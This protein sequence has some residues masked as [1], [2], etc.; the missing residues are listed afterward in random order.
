MYVAVV[1][2]MGVHGPAMF[3]ADSQR[4]T[5]PLKPATV[6]VPLFVVPQTLEFAGVTVPGVEPAATDNCAGLLVAVGLQ[7]P[8]TKQR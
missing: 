2:A 5:F 8:V 7:V 4:T 3:V 6:N 1:L